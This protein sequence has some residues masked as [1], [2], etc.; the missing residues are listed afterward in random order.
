M[1]EKTSHATIPLKREESI[2]VRAPY[3]VRTLY[4][5]VR[6]TRREFSCTL[7]SIPGKIFGQFSKNPI[8]NIIMSLWN[9]KKQRIFLNF[10][11][12]PQCS[13]IWDN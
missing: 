5:R 3:T 2:F 12:E 10:L 11:V 7:I 13:H 8:Q 4:R 9:M 1:I 6:D